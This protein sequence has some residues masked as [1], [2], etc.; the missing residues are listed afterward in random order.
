MPGAETVMRAVDATPQEADPALAA[1]AHWFARVHGDH[2][3]ME[4]I[5]GWQRWLAENAANRQAF[6]RIEDLWEAMG[7]LPRAVPSTT[8]WRSL[9]QP[10]A[11]AAAVLLAVVGVGYLVWSPGRPPVLA[12]AASVQTRVAEDRSYRLPD[13]SRVEIGAR[14]RIAVDFS[15]AAR[16]IVIE[17]GEAYFE[18]APEPRPFVVVA[19]EASI[20]AVGTAFNVH[21]LQGR[22]AV[23]VV[24]GSVSV[25]AAPAAFEAPDAPADSGTVVRAGQALTYEGGALVLQSTDSAPTVG[26]RSGRLQYVRE[27]LGFVAPDV[28]RYSDTQI[29]V[30]DPQVGELLY[31]GSIRRDRIDEWLTTL[32]VVL[33]VEIVRVDRETVLLVRRGST[34]LSPGAA[35]P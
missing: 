33:P 30:D 32:S 35:A 17:S 19:G 2:P 8:P 10:L 3:T 25:A 11:L 23:T 7:E 6:E 22:V 9:R 14:T 5:A 28:S 26:W 13:G 29:I 20:T 4:D 21:H 16:R 31:T 34:A 1:A 12:E 15:P 24:E 27:P 18:V